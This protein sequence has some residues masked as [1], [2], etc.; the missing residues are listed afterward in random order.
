MKSANLKKSVRCLYRVL[1]QA[2]ANEMGFVSLAFAP[3]QM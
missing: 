2:E 3:D 1:A